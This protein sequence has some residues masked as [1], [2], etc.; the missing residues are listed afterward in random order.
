MSTHKSVPHKKK[1]TLVASEHLQSAG[2]LKQNEKQKNETK[3]HTTNLI[4][5]SSFVYLQL[6]K[7]KSTG[8]KLCWVFE[9]SVFSWNGLWNSWMQCLE[10][11]CLSFW[12]LTECLADRL[13]GGE[14]KVTFMHLTMFFLV[15]KIS[16]LYNGIL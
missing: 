6:K 15:F 10:W 1:H 4:F 3:A 14:I 16:K 8:S 9:A 11:E 13:A 2:N 5:F 7:P 12:L